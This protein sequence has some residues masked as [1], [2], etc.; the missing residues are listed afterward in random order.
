MLI[1]RDVLP[2]LYIQVEHLILL[3]LMNDRYRHSRLPT[4]SH[5]Y[6][7]QLL[8]RGLLESS[9]AQLLSLVAK[10]RLVLRVGDFTTILSRFCESFLQRIKIIRYT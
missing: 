8:F 4:K 10:Q 2:C 6:L 1:Y 9:Y 5:G 7:E 3:C